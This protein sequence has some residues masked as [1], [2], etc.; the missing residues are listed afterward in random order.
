MNSRA[1]PRLAHYK[2]SLL[3]TKDKND[4]HYIL[5]FKYSAA[6]P[7]FTD[8]FSQYNNSEI[9]MDSYQKIAAHLHHNLMRVE[10]VPQLLEKLKAIKHDHDF[11]TAR[12]NGSLPFTPMEIITI[13]R[14]LKY[15]M[16]V[17]RRAI[18]HLQN[19]ISI[20]NREIARLAEDFKPLPKNGGDIGVSLFKSFS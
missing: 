12:Q 16:N 8:Y 13:K 10:I 3:K 2:D 6:N 9:Q 7:K 11:V 17:H 1:I 15:E 14:N 18:K 19:L 4:H 5:E 20:T